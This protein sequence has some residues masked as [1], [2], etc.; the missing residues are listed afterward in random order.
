MESTYYCNLNIKSNFG[1]QKSPQKRSN[2]LQSVSTPPP[3]H[4]PPPPQ[5][6]KIMWWHPWSWNFFLLLFFLCIIISL[7][8]QRQRNLNLHY[9]VNFN[10]WKKVIK[11]QNFKRKVQ[12]APTFV[13]CQTDTP[14]I[15]GR[16]TWIFTVSN[17]LLYIIQL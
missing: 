9:A 10:Q 12:T 16:Y 13:A 7:S 11:I 14:S 4:P 15:S 6:K 8:L 5:K 2:I 3:V 1:T 17:W